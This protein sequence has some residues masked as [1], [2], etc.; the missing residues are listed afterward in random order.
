MSKTDKNHP[1]EEVELG[2]LFKIIG[3]GFENIFRLL[4]LFLVQFL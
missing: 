3:K 4:D 1:N 2:Q